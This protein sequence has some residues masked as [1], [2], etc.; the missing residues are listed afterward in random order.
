M[1]LV[2]AYLYYLRMY[3]FP[4]ILYESAYQLTKT[5]HTDICFNNNWKLCNPKSLFD[6]DVQTMV[7]VVNTN[8]S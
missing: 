2:G 1:Q 4:H 5:K 3:K 6:T 7:T 8:S